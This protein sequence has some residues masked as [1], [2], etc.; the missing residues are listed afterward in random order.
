MASNDAISVSNSSFV[1]SDESI[2][3]RVEDSLED[4]LS[5]DALSLGLPATAVEDSVCPACSKDLP[6]TAEYGLGR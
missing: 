5:G 1:N 6:E 2:V 4:L 3:M